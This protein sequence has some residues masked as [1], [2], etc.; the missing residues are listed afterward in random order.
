MDT[1]LVLVN[2]IESKTIAIFLILVKRS[3]QPKLKR[4]FTLVKENSNFGLHFTVNYKIIQ[5]KTLFISCCAT[6]AQ[7]PY[8]M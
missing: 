3:F 6:K 1:I 5:I 4:L 7:T 8:P 2:F